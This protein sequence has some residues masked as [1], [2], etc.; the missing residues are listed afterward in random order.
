MTLLTTMVEHHIWLVS[1][2]V[3]LAARLEA[4]RLDAPITLSVET[5]DDGPTLRSLLSRLIGQMDMWNN[6]I[7]SRPY[8]FG[9]ERNES[10]E[11]MR[12]R[13]AKAGPAFLAEVRAVVEEGRLDETFVDAH[14]EPAEVFSYGGL[15]AHVLTF[16]AHRRLLVLGALESAGVNDLGNGDPRRWVDKVA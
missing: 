15:I 8:D 12:E 1:E 6:V 5:L 7:A 13:L 10:V 2:M 11:S 16:A 14:C 9:I 4:E 3:D